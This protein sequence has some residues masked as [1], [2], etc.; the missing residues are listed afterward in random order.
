[1]AVR[2]PF[3]LPAEVVPS[4]Y[5]ISLKPDLTAF[6]FAGSESITVTVRKP[7]KPAHPRRAFLPP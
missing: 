2:N 5:D 7:T 1:M 3:L 6:T 4:H